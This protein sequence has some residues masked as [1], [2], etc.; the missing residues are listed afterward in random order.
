MPCSSRSPSSHI[1]CP[2]NSRSYYS[3]SANFGECPPS[4]ASA[5]LPR[6]TGPFLRPS[7]LDQILHKL[8]ELEQS[9]LQGLDAPQA[10]FELC[11]PDVLL[12]EPLIQPL[13]GRQGHP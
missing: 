12:D 6:T 13:N 11:D 1:Q 2:A 5:C 8:L 3:Y 7:V 4:R 9:K 10:G